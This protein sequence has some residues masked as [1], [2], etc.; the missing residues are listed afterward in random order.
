I[1]ELRV[2]M[3][4]DGPEIP[5]HLLE[6]QQA[7][8]DDI[9]DT[10]SVLQNQDTDNGLRP[11]DLPPTLRSQ[12]VGVTGHFRVMVFPKKDVWQRENQKEFIEQ[13]RR[14][15]PEKRVTGTPVQLFEYE[16]TLKD[17]YQQ[18]AWYALGAI[19]LMV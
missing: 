16:K 3:F 5:R 8:F 6:Y 4:S 19:A 17:S 14:V 11:E 1:I 15:I 18:A 9:R 10:F 12:F 13:L 2:K 7:L